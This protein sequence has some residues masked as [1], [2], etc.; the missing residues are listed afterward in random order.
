VEWATFPANNV[1]DWDSVDVDSASSI[2]DRESADILLLTSSSKVDWVIAD[3][4]W[5]TLL[6]LYVTNWA[7]V[8]VDWV[9]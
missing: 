4:D 9:T 5:V 7:S 6:E 1:M 8:N 3:G 2:V